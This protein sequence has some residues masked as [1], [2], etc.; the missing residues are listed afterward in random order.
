MQ[1]DCQWLRQVGRW[2]LD[3]WRDPAGVP[4]LARN[5]VAGLKLPADG[6]ARRPMITAERYSKVREAAE[7]VMMEDRAGAHERRPSY[8]AD[9]LEL[10]W[11][12]GHRVTAVLRLRWEDVLPEQD[13]MPHGALRWSGLNDKTNWEHTVPMSVGIRAVID[14]IRRARPGLGAAYLFPKPTSRLAPISKERVRTWLLKA[15]ELAKVPK[16]DGSLFHAYRRGWATARKHH[17]LVDVALAGGW[18]RTETLMRHYV[19]ADAATT[20]RVLEEAT[21][22]RE[23]QA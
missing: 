7:R 11:L 18:K 4:I 21:Q 15:E 13:D 1:A 9:I 14:R 5:P 17:S 16:Q 12:T 8:L 10:L 3:N 20:I 19:Q 2:A 6:E 23:R 22:V